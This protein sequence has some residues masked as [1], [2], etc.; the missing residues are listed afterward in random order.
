MID[1]NK[2]NKT[3][4][5]Y[6]P[7]IGLEIH[8]ELKTKSKMF[9]GCKNDH[10]NAVHPNM[11][12]CPV[13]LGMPGGLPKPNIKAIK[14]ILKLGM[15]LNGKINKQTH[16]DR[17]HYNYPDL[18]KGYQ[19]S[20]YDKPFCFDA[21]VKTS[22]G[23]VDIERIHLEEDT[24]KLIH[25]TIKDEKVT[26]I[27]FNRSGV[28]LVEI[29]TKPT[30]VSAKQA[31]EYAKE[32]RKIV[33]YLDIS[34]ADMQKGEMRL[35]ANVSL[36]PK[37]LK[38]KSLPPY[39]VEV[40]NINSFNFLEQAINYEIVRQGEILD[41]E[42]TPIQETRGFDPQKGITYSQR[43]KEDA[44]DYRYFPDPDI[45]PISLT[46]EFLDGIKNSLPL[47]YEDFINTWKSK[48]D[49]PEEKSEKL[50]T[51][52]KQA[53]FMNKLFSKAAKS[54]ITPLKL[55]ND[56]INK[57]IMINP[58]ASPQSIIDMHKKINKKA[59]LDISILDL[60]VD[61]VLKKNTDAVEKYKQG[62]KKVIAYLLGQVKYRLQQKNVDVK[63]IIDKIKEAIK[64]Y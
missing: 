1:T 42:D 43:I 39:K 56:I 36:K 53:I 7:I 12:T 15:Y 17:K 41:N 32:L 44:L 46:N 11:Y 54:G 14:W 50:F 57:K 48:Y 60:I 34:N 35:E 2:L 61:E 5:K 37:Y 6:K 52:Y 62:N 47:K 40:K 55:A 64:N 27:D 31:K 58:K 30:I 33:R 23:I 26:L 3:L 16:F 20:Q 13:C 45:P 21:K 8:I 19:I 51:T 29:V 63:V 4:E 28:P 59:S 25:T 38:D 9:C 24:A 22:T 49:I 10:F 18:P